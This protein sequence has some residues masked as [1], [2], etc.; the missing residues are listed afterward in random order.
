MLRTIIENAEAHNRAFDGI[1]RLF[2]PDLSHILSP[3]IAG[4]PHTGR[5]LKSLS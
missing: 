4:L 3:A 2:A 1:P 5:C